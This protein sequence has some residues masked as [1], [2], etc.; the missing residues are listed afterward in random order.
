MRAETTSSDAEIMRGATSAWV[1]EWYWIASRTARET[2]LRKTWV[3]IEQHAAEKA[4]PSVVKI[5]VCAKHED[6]SGGR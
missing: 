1:N 5:D 3:S 6:G 2:I 4:Q